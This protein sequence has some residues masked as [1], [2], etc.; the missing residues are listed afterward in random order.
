MKK[1][2]NIEILI[3]TYVAFINCLPEKAKGFQQP[4]CEIPTVPAESVTLPWF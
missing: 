4:Y 3:N 2:Q 1:G